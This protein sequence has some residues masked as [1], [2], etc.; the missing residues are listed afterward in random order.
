M[1]KFYFQ[2]LEKLETGAL[3]GNVDVARFG[4]REHAAA[5]CA[6]RDINTWF[7]VPPAPV[8]ASLGPGTVVKMSRT[9][10][11]QLTNPQPRFC[12]S[13]TGTRYGGFKPISVIR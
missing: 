11:K 12:T 1:L 3:L 13:K 10:S 8:D 6:A 9:L 4:C 5:C 2:I 7:Q